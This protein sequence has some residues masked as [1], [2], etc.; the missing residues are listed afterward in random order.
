[1]VTPRMARWLCLQD[2][3]RS[4]K[5]HRRAAVG[6]HCVCVKCC[7]MVDSVPRWWLSLSWPIESDHL[8]IPDQ[9][10]PPLG[11]EHS[12]GKTQH[13]PGKQVLV[14][15]IYLFYEVISTTCFSHNFHAPNRMHSSLGFQEVYSHIGKLHYCTAAVK[16]S[17][18][19]L[20]ISEI[21]EC[22]CEKSRN[23]HIIYLGE[24]DWNIYIHARW[25]HIDKLDRDIT[26]VMCQKQ[27]KIHIPHQ[28]LKKE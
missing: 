1:M 8:S 9:M 3:S 19:A 2:I 22:K 21:P 13:I 27:K 4:A 7:R 25:L 17:I 14:R 5:W 10:I 12:H 20:F 26:Y 16:N 6:F 28:D 11:Q 24:H 23:L 15:S 18:G